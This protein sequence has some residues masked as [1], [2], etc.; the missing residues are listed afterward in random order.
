MNKEQLEAKRE[1]VRNKIEIATG[2]NPHSLQT[3]YLLELLNHLVTLVDKGAIDYD[4]VHARELGY[5]KTYPLVE[6]KG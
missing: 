1:E 2:W 3:D 4:T 6:V 5:H